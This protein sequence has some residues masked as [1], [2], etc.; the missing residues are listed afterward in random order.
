MQDPRVVGWVLQG[1][2]MPYSSGCVLGSSLCLEIQGKSAGIS[3]GSPG[4]M[5]RSVGGSAMA[6]NSMIDAGLQSPTDDEENQRLQLIAESREMLEKLGV[7]LNNHVLQAGMHNTMGH[8]DPAAVFHPVQTNSLVQPQAQTVAQ[9]QAQAGGQIQA[10]VQTV[11]QAQA[12]AGGQIQAQVQTVAQATAQPDVQALVN[13]HHD[14]F[15]PFVTPPTRH[16][17][18]AMIKRAKHMSR[19]SELPV[20]E[21]RQYHELVRFLEDQFSNVYSPRQPHSLSAVRFEHQVLTLEEG[22]SLNFQYTPSSVLPG[23]E[24]IR[25]GNLHL[26]GAWKKPAQA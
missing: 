20:P 10:Q 9:A 22:H 26:P 16:R 23:G 15:S 8:S 5:A 25:Y 19:D 24:G 2:C 13:Q 4:D 21:M 12:Q 17:L 11:A 1:L 7:D 14:M 6:P 18:H 3:L